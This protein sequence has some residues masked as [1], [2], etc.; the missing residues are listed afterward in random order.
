MKNIGSVIYRKG[1]K[2]GSLS[3][4]WCHSDYGNGTGIATSVDRS[5]DSFAGVYDIQYFDNIGGIQ[6]T[7]KLK[8]ESCDG[9]FQLSWFNNGNLTATGIG[10]E[11]NGVLSVGYCDV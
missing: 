3:A 5:G 2:I 1:E 8:I 9:F 10:Q 7:L 11:N 6:A 4:K